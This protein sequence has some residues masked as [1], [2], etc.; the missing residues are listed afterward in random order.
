MPVV[1]YYLGRPADVLISA[2]SRRGPARARAAD[3][4]PAA[5]PVAAPAR[6]RPASGAG[7]P[8]MSPAGDAPRITTALASVWAGYWLSGHGLP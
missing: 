2:M 8:G 5:P 4:P 3:A 7:Q 6:P 1:H